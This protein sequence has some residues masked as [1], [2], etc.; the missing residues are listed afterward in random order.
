MAR[1]CSEQAAA[2]AHARPQ[3]RIG[4]APGS[5]LHTGGQGRL[6]VPWSLSSC[7]RR[8]SVRSLSFQRLL[9]ALKPFGGPWTTHNQARKGPRNGK[10]TGAPTIGAVVWGAGRRRCF[11]CRVLLALASCARW[12]M[13][14]KRHTVTAGKGCSRGGG[15]AWPRASAWTHKGTPGDRRQPQKK[16]K[17]TLALGGFFQEG[18][19]GPERG[20][21]PGT[22]TKKG[23]G[24]PAHTPLCSL[25]SLGFGGCVEAARSSVDVATP[26]PP[27]REKWP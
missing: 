4:A 21:F 6:H 25:H 3:S 11:G 17:K 14:N 8:S 9:Q 27:C 5:L 7:R 22:L 19:V 2:N 13:K 16:E 12:W 10:A 18:V 15:Q 24:C 23:R 20:G 1:L 26:A